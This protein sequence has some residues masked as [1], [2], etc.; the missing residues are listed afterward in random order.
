MAYDQSFF[1]NV[2]SSFAATAPGRSFMQGVG[3]TLGIH[4]QKGVSKGFL[5]R[6]A[7]GGMFGKGLLGRALFPAFT[8]VAAYTGY[9]EG[10]VMGAA[11]N[12]ATEAL[13]WGA[14]RAGFTML[15]NPA[16]LGGAAIAGAGYGMYRLGEAARTHERR[17]RSLELGADVVDRFGTLSTMRQRSLQAIQSSHLNGRT[18]LGNEALLLSTPYRR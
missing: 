14:M 15:T 12:V 16:I 2:R 3:E 6:K 9:K 5:G 4:Y 10:G 13:M 8:A 11:K 7:P 17:V 18:A 1:Q